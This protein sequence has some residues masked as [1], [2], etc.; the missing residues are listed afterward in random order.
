MYESVVIAVLCYFFARCQINDMPGVTSLMRCRHC[1]V[2]FHF[3]WV[4]F[5][6]DSYFAADFPCTSILTHIHLP[7]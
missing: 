3:V 2:A 4:R 7:A 6:F 5:V 1:I